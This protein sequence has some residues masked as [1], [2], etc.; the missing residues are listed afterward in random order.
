LR[1]IICLG[2]ASFASSVSMRALDP[3][4]PIVA[5]DLHVSLAQ[6]AW[7]ASAYS[8]PYAIMQL[9]LGPAADAFGKVRLICCALA[10]VTLGSMICVLAP[11]FGGVMAGRI[12]AGGSGGGVIP[13]AFAL[14]GDR[15]PYA[16]RQ[17]TLSRVL[18][19][20]IAEHMTG[21]IG[22]GAIASLLG[23]RVV[24]LFAALLAAASLTV[25]YFFLVSTE[26]QG[27]RPKLGR[28]FAS[29]L[30][31]LTDRMALLI[32]GCVAV[33]GV[34]FFGIFPFLAPMLTLHG[35]SNGGMVAAG[36]VLAGFALGGV[37]YG[38]IARPVIKI[39]GGLNMLR[40][41]GLVAGSIYLASAAPW[42]WQDISLMFFVGGFGF[43]IM[44]NT[45]QLRA[46]ELAP[47]ARGASLALFA[48]SFFLGQG[49]GPI[50]GAAV[51]QA[52]GY[53]VMYGGAGLL[54]MALGLA[55]AAAI[56]NFSRMSPQT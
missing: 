7:L 27:E 26:E 2:L 4:L 47:S 28:A 32:F 12:I 45:F 24:F 46:T 8:F 19:I 35:A 40:L 55:S 14:I 49:T 20:S 23:W 3:M 33:E 36:V 11:E 34:L 51:S 54:I 6:A 37:A 52:W 31:V 15:I 38:A 13:V 56:K 17:I 25:V 48:A 30:P 43:Y 18:I 44:H 39:L 41:G 1:L 10:G 9:V 21:A 22:S 53:A 50:L 42:P 5:S 16:E 29:Y